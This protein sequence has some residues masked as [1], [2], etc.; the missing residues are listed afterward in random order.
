MR[1]VVNNNPI[2]LFLEEGTK[3]HGPVE[4]KALFIPLTRRAV[5]A[6]ARPFGIQ[7]TPRGII[8][9]VQTRGKTS[10]RTLIYGIDYVLTQHV[11]GIQAMHIAKKERS[12]AKALLLKLFKEYVRGVI[13]RSNRR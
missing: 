6:T 1:V 13:A 2:M 3:A 5:N 11:A 7:T 12:K 9:K 10:T 8:Q 4:A